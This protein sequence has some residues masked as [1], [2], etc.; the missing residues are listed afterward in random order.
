MSECVVFVCDSKYWN[1]FIYT[2]DLLIRNGKYNGDICLVVGDDLKYLTSMP[3]DFILKNKI[4]VK[5]F[6]NI[7]F[8]DNFMKNFFSLK[9]ADYW[10]QKIFQY[11]KFYLFDIF[12]KKWKYIFYIDCGIRIFDNIHPILNLKTENKLLA[13]SDA[14]P[15]YVWKLHDQFSKDDIYFPKLNSSFDL[16]CDYC[17]TTI[18]LYDT[19][20]I[21][22]NTFKDLL[23]LSEEYPISITNDQ[24]IIALYFTNIR[25][26][27]E[28]IQ[29]KNDNTYFYDYQRRDPK[30]NHIML[31]S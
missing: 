23:D 25:K 8:S 28:Q 29:I 4:I 26:F 10:N 15:T 19:N 12:F 24:G 27:F 1:K 14:Y 3:N 2:C 22:T 20:L 16:N 30:N 21:E 13:H 6:P 11:H 7:K 9:R 31:K 5:H 18:M 17:Q